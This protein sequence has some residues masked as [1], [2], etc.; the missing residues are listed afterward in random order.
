MEC[1]FVLSFLYCSVLFVFLTQFL[2]LFSIKE[3]AVLIL[4]K[5]PFVS[6]PQFLIRVHMILSDQ[7]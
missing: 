4:L 7:V 2:L 3:A 6:K 1:S 5:L